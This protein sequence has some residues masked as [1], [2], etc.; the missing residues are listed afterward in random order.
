MV[1]LEL[2]IV[3][4]FTLVFYSAFFLAV[5]SISLCKYTSYRSLALYLRIR[6]QKK[7]FCQSK[8]IGFNYVRNQIGRND[9]KFS[10]ENDEIYGHI[11]RSDIAEKEE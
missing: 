2:N 10:R 1:F 11:C 9:K 4:Q 6:C 5:R 3:I 7:L 8:G